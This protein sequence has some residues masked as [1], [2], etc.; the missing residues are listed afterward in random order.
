MAAYDS[1][2]QWKDDNVMALN[3]YAYYLSEQGKDLHKAE[4]M[5]YKT[6]KAEPNNGTYL[7]TYAWILFMQERYADAKTYIDAALKNRDSTENNSAVLEH[8]GDI[9]AMNGITDEAVEYWKKAKTDD[10]PSPT[11]DWKIKNK[12][13]ISEEEFQKRMNPAVAEVKKQKATGKA[14]GRKTKRGRKK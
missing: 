4:S 5:S 6:I 9:Y 7:D 1:C 3:N 14:T 8:A 11:L 13:Y 10:Y 12:Q 2:L